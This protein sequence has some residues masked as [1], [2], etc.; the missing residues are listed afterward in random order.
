MTATGKL[1][2]IAFVHDELFLEGEVID[3]PVAFVKAL[4]KQI[5]RLDIPFF[6]AKNLRQSSQALD[7]F[8]EL[9]NAAAID[10]TDYNEWWEKKLP[11]EARK[12]YAEGSKERGYGPS[13]QVR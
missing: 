8:F 5:V 9:D 2:K 12:E 1:L 11:Q 6:S 13:G 7:Y 10:T 3:D 4:K